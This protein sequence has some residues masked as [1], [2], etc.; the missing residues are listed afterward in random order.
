M[1]VEVSRCQGRS[2]DV[3]A[4]QGKSGMSGDV[5]RG[6]ARSPEVK[7]IHDDLCTYCSQVG[8]GRVVRVGAPG[9]H[10]V[11]QH[12]AKVQQYCYLHGTAIATATAIDTGPS[13]GAVT[14]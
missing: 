3:R 1:S 6:H 4:G 10:G 5:R 12:L 2:R 13:I 14:G 8:D 11:D 9:P 7:E